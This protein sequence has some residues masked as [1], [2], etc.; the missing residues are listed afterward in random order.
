MDPEPTTTPSSAPV[1]DLRR[2]WGIFAV[3]WRNAIVREMQFKANFLLW[4]VV[5]FLWFGLQLTF[6]N[7]IY[8]HTEQI[9]TWS[10]WEVVMLAG[11]AQ[12][13]QQ[14]CSGIF[15][16]NIANLSNHIRTGR[17]DFMLLLPANTRFLITFQKVDLGEFINAAAALVVV[18]Y[19]AAKLGLSISAG[20]LVG[21]ALLCLAGMLTHYSL[22]FALA[23][24][25]FWT[26]RAEGVVWGYFNLFNLARLPDAAFRGAF[27]AFFTFAIPML[28]VA[29]VPT[30]V[31]ANTLESPMELV[32][33][34]G[35]A[36]VAAILSSLF[37]NFSVRRYTSASS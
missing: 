10:K 6:V 9:A 30:K 13:I 8:L 29:N 34:F 22:M 25:A 16:S 11:V 20:Q 19:A 14:V 5:D 15:I 28:V 31:I 35:L 4:V 17:L 37:W 32:L 12:F 33:A 7:V 27:R 24:V 3:L 2:Y 36:V 18:G 26:V 21:F 23:S 1:S